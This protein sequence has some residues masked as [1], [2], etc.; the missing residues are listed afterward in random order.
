LFT[1]ED[2]VENEAPFSVFLR[3]L[4]KFPDFKKLDV[5]ECLQII[6][7][8]HQSYSPSPPPFISTNESGVAESL[9]GLCIFGIDELL[10]SHD[11]KDNP[12]HPDAQEFYSNLTTCVGLLM[13]SWHVA[14]GRKFAIMPVV[15][16]LSQI[17]VSNTT[18][19][20]NRSIN[21]IPLR[22]LAGV[23]VEVCKAL[24]AKYDKIDESI[25]QAVHCLCLFLGEH[26]R[27][28]EY[29]VDLLIERRDLFGDLKARGP[30]AIPSILTAL[31]S[32]SAAYMVCV[33]PDTLSMFLCVGFPAYV[34]SSPAFFKVEFCYDLS[35][36]KALCQQF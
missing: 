12:H 30:E 21:W 31:E 5:D 13:N 4:R 28:L 18:Q 33:F 36:P 27:L 24:F 29:L 9:P 26:G 14:G 35:H 1:L 16:S 7:E 6:L 23:E 8:H 15:T 10:K 17:I 20:S 25:R 34:S 19:R 32:K 3:T 2:S 11:L 22:P